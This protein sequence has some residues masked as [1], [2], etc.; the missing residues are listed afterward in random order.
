MLIMGGRN[1]VD[2][3]IITELDLYNATTNKWITLT[4]VSFPTSLLGTDNSCSSLGGTS[5]I[6]GGYNSDYSVSYGS[7]AS[8][9]LFSNG[10]SGAFTSLA[11]MPR[12]IGDF[13]SVILGSKIYVYGGYS[14]VYTPAN[15]DWTCKPL[16]SLYIYDITSNSWQT[17]SDLPFPLAEKDDGVV[18]G[19]RIFSIGGETKRITSGCIDTDIVALKNVFAYNPVMGTWSNET[20]LPSSIMRFASAEYGGS[21][22]VFGGQMDIIDSNTL[23][24]SY[25]VWQY[26]PFPVPPSSSLISI[27]YYTGFSSG[28]L[29]LSVILS[30]VLTL[31]ATCVLMRV[32]PKCLNCL[33]CGAPRCCCGS[34]SAG[35]P[36]HGVDRERADSIQAVA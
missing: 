30:I 34:T 20:W 7:M 19:G 22:Y 23:P 21:I 15:P 11:T 24:L 4:A 31:G 12:G 6:F 2:D 8:F 32:S 26:N 35:I 9:K 5:Y 13:S 14:T 29:A 16:T 10:L 1:V 3:S 27:F 25:K 18:I 28:T 33:K 36:L 17:G